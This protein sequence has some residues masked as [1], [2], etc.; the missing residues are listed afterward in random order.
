MLLLSCIHYFSLPTGFLSIVKWAHGVEH[1]VPPVTPT[2]PF[3]LLITRLQVWSNLIYF[4]LEN[5]YYF[6]AHN[7]LPISPAKQNWYSN[8]GCRFWA[9]HV[10]LDL[11]RLWREHSLRAR[12]RKAQQTDATSSKQDRAAEFDWYRQLI[13]NLGY[14][15]LTVHWSVDGG[16]GLSDVQVGIC[17]TFAAIG[18]LLGQWRANA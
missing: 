9:A 6:G 14:L 2:D 10:V 8:I 4:P 13:I 16:I 3:I 11:L 5:L 17:G 12:A 18:Q 1:P 15:P 7:I